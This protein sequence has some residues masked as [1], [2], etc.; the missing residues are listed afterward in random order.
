LAVLLRAILVGSIAALG[1][2]GSGGAATSSTSVRQPAS[3]NDSEPTTASSS[4]PTAA[5]QTTSERTP[6][7]V[8]PS[9]ANTTAPPPNDEPD[10]G[11]ATSISVSPTVVEI[12]D[13]VRVDVRCLTWTATDFDGRV[14]GRQYS[15]SGT[16]TAQVEY[17]VAVDQIRVDGSKPFGSVEYSIDYPIVA[18][19]EPGPMEITGGC[20][21]FGGHPT[22]IEVDS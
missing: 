3:F 7:S 13:V 9:S 1:A 8:L 5:V 11:G 18:E 10:Q 4:S 16:R 14:V 17:E 20:D 21:G 2:C 19:F 22:W 12:G 15:G 6:V